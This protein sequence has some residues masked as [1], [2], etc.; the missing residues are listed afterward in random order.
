MSTFAVGIM[1]SEFVYIERNKT[2]DDKEL[3]G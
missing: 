2:A 1:V 3:G